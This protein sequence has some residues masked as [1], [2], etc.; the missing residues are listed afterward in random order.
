M[1]PCRTRGFDLRDGQALA[2]GGLVEQEADARSGLVLGYSIGVHAVFFDVS[3][4]VEVLRQDQHP[5]LQTLLE[6]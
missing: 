6:A 5:G 1:S 4:G 2:P 3:V